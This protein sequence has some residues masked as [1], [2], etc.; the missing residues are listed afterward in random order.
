[1]ESLSLWTQRAGG[2]IPVSPTNIWRSFSSSLILS[3][4]SHVLDISFWRISLSSLLIHSTA[5]LFF[6]LFRLSSSNG[7]TVGTNINCRF[8]LKLL[9][10]H[11]FEWIDSPIVVKINLLPTPGQLHPLIGSDSGQAPDLAKLT[12][13]AAVSYL[14]WVT[15][16]QF[17]GVY[18][19]YWGTSEA[20]SFVLP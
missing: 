19:K 10:Q 5:K 3:L 7:D 6:V 8:D 17:F 18:I 12:I 16:C 14:T 9:P 20:L 1:M 15:I 4:V 2:Y 11:K 13:T